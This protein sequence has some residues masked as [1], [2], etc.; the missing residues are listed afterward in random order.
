M[1]FSKPRHGLDVVW[2]SIAEDESRVNNSSLEATAFIRPARKWWERKVE[3]KSALA[4][5]TEFHNSLVCGRDRTPG[6][7]EDDARE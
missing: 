1:R 5:D 4:D 7:V 3:H 6:A 2:T